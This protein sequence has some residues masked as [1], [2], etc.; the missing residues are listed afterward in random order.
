[1]A[2]AWVCFQVWI[3]LAGLACGVILPG[4]RG[5]RA[6]WSPISS[7]SHGL[8]GRGEG[9][10]N[11]LFMTGM[12]LGGTLGS[13]LWPCWPGRGALGGVASVG[14]GLALVACLCAPAGRRPLQAAS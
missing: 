1:M 9:A 7:G 3:S 10:V 13:T 11:T 6:H 8:R 5:Y 12:F 2:L 4:S 14:M